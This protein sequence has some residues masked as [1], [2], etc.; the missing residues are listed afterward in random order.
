M[1]RI[2]KGVVNA[3]LVQRKVVVNKYKE[4]IEV[5]SFGEFQNSCNWTA[6]LL[7]LMGFSATISW[8]NTNSKS[9]TDDDAHS[10]VRGITFCLAQ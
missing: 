6:W 9:T 7:Q 5:Q 4:Y 3:V 1:R 10:M 2:L 8:Y